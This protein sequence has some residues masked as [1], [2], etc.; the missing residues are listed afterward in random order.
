MGFPETKKSYLLG[1]CTVGSWGRWW[2]D[3]MISMKPFP[4]V[5]WS[6]MVIPPL[7]G[8]LIS[9]VYK[10]LRNWVDDHPL[11][12]GNNG[13]WSTLAHIR[14][15]TLPSDIRI[16]TGPLSG[17]L[18]TVIIQKTSQKLKIDL[19]YIEILMCQNFSTTIFR[20]HFQ[21]NIIQKLPKPSLYLG[22]L[23][24]KSFWMFRPFWRGFP[25]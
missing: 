20:Y 22:N 5:P 13:S 23:W 21:T 15:Y 10:P 9:W 1:A 14:Y 16:I 2:F 7:I 6:G 4:H 12:Y 8:I 17:S 3:Q 11:L 18:L 24:N 25:Y 19:V